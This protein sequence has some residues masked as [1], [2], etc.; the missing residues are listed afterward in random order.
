VILDG[1]KPGE[2][3]IVGG[4]MLVRPNAPVA[5]KSAV[6]KTGGESPA[7]LAADG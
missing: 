5:P 1:L 7:R 6:G 3:V 4:T 2:E